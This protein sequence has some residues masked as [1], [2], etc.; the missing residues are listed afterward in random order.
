MDVV[1][2]V[3]ADFRTDFF[4]APS[5]LAADLAGRSVLAHTLGRLGAWTG[6]TASFWPGRLTGRKGS[7][8]PSA[9]C[10]FRWW[11]I[12]DPPGGCGRPCGR[13]GRSALRLARRA[14]RHD[15]LRRT[16]R[17]GPDRLRAGEPQPRGPL[18][19]PG[20]RGAAGRGLGRTDDRAFPR[21]PRAVPLHLQP[22]PA[23]PGRRGVQR[24]NPAGTYSGR[25]V[26]RPDVRLQPGR[27][28]VRPDL[29]GV[30]LHAAAEDR[31][32]AAAV[33]RRQ[34]ARAVA[35]PAD[36]RSR[37]PRRRRRGRLP[38]R[39]RTGPRALAAGTDHRAD[40]PPRA[41]GR[42]SPLGRPR[43]PEAGRPG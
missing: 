39:Q 13:P 3:Y 25:A 5:Q 7:A 33:H 36:R 14:G 20:R 37:R 12:S 32:H 1:A 17:H 30:Q 26:P 9:T 35:L 34:P 10:R 38:D 8:R 22:G 18:P 41:G 23:G 2:L 31:L 16:V 11:T 40:H 4:G 15:G 42:P 28:A 27:A 19:G 21:P 29:H 6:W 43:G 24:R